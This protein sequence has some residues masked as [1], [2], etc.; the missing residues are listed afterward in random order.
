M[1]NTTSSAHEFPVAPAA[2]SIGEAEVSFA[3]RNV[4]TLSELDEVVESRKLVIAKFGKS[5]CVG[6]TQMDTALTHLKDR[7]LLRGV[8]L[9]KASLETM[10]LRSYQQLSIRQAPTTIMYV[11]GEEIYR[12]SGFNSERTVEEAV[13]EHLLSTEYNT[14][15]A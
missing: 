3:E 4:H 5:N 13:I 10:G 11:N 7:G 9:V 6:C 8:T 15:P 1:L 2:T 14:E 12:L